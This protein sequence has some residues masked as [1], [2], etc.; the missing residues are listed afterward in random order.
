MYQIKLQHLGLAYLG[1][2]FSVNEVNYVSNNFSNRDFNKPKPRWLIYQFVRH[3]SDPFSISHCVF[4]GNAMLF[5]SEIVGA[6]AGCVE[7]KLKLYLGKR[8]QVYNVV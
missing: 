6:A 5:R 8:N 2:F 7:T 1:A 4:T 3:Y